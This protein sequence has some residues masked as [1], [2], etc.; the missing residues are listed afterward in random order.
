[1]SR[2]S[3]EAERLSHLAE[4]LL[5]IARSDGGRLP[6]RPEPLEID[7]L[8]AAVVTRFEWRASESGRPL[9]ALP[10][11]LR[12]SGDR[13]RLEQALSNLVDNALRHGAGPVD[14]A[15][16]AGDGGVELHVRDGGAGFATEV[17]G[18]AFERFARGDPAR[19]GVGAGLG[20]S[21]V[22]AIANAH[23]GSAHAANA[24]GADVWMALPDQA[25]TISRPSAR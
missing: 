8:F 11:G 4:D 22:R 19:A 13:L 1:M 2:A 12:I 3:E 18:R 23:G 16:S 25:S 21:I 20:L 7:D 17:L 9:R 10:S 5:L 15:A 14:L 24:A 6:L